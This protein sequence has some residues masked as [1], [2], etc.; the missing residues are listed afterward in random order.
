[1]PKKLYISIIALVFVLLIF[2]LSLMNYNSKKAF[3]KPEF[4]SSAVSGIPD[5]EDEIYYKPLDAD[6]LYSISLYTK[7]LI[8]NKNLI[9]YLTSSKENNNYVKVRILKKEKIIGES[10][11]IKPGEY[12]KSIKLNSSLKKGDKITIKI[13]GYETET[14]YSYGVITV[15]SDVR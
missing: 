13:M 8:D 7:P 14:Y 2:Y 10:G 12:I 6:N 3:K 9:I 1:M 15:D 11:L 5:V 4:D